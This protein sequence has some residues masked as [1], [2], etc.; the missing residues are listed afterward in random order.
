MILG[1][2]YEKSECFGPARR[3]N[4]RVRAIDVSGKLTKALELESDNKIL[5]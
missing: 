1:Y 4:S 5:T 2:K 3:K